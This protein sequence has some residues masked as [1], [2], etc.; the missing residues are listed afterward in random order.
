M[1]VVLLADVDKVGK[2]YDVKEVADG[3]ARNFLIPKSLAK[4]ATKEMLE[5]VELQKQTTAQ[6]AEEDL[7]KVQGLAS[8]IDGQE[9]ILTVKIGP[10]GQL[11]ETINAQK[12]V[13]RIK[14]MGF[15][16]KKSQLDL[17]EPI[18]EVGEYPIRIKLEHNLEAQIQVII[19]GEEKPADEEE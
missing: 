7:K 1:K 5:W 4:V 6:K 19:N 2:K 10:E 13:E 18:R 11:F 12:I 14:E 8:S 15:E 9:V 3:F 17:A 16:I